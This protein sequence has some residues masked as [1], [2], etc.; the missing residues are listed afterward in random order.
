MHTGDKL[1]VNVKEKNAIVT[2]MPAEIFP[3]YV[4]IRVNEFDKV[5]VTPMEEWMRYL[6]SGVIR[7]D[8]TAPG[9]EEARE[10]LKYYSMTPQE[11][12]AYDEH[13]TAVMIQ[14]D[15]IDSAKLEGRLE[16]RLEGK[17]EGRLEGKIEGRLEGIEQE[18]LSNAR[19]MKDKGLDSTM[20]ADIT[21]L[22]LDEIARL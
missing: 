20:I 5:A 1:Q 16:G 4:L 2:R 9:L 19:K 15:V 21:G 3:E 12:M 7:P 8:T 13:L 14:N 10:K 22:S 18:R 6:K 11:R 17:I